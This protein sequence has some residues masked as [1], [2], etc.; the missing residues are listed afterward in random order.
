MTHPPQEVLLKVMC[1]DKEPD[2]EVL[3][4]DGEGNQLFGWLIKTFHGNFICES[5]EHG[6]DDVLYYYEPA[7]R[8][9]LTVEEWFII[10]EKLRIA[11]E[12]V[13]E[14]NKLKTLNPP[15]K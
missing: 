1:S 11:D 13:L 3:C 8:I 4:E 2:N 15:T 6:L 5:E 14:I 9:V 7:T 12:I 10:E